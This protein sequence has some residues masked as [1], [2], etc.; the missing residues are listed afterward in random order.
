[1]LQK[2]I[3]P[4]VKNIYKINSGDFTESD[5]DLI[6]ISV[7]HFQAVCRRNKDMKEYVKPCEILL[8][9]VMGE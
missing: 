2:F 3:L 8:D 9:K 4:I 5:L 1:M 7:N 6:I